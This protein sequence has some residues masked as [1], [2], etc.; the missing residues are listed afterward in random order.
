MAG[1]A[2]AEFLFG[3]LFDAGR[4]AAFAVERRGRSVLCANPRFEDLIGRR[5]AELVGQPMSAL[6]IGELDYR[7]DDIVDRA[8]LY[9]DVAFGQLDGYPLFVDLT[10]AHV[11]H[12]ELGPLAACLARDTTE[13]RTLQRE[14]MA[15]HSAL[16]L[17]HSELADRNREISLLAGQVARVGWRAAI[18]ELAAGVAHHLNNPVAALTSTLRT[19]G[20][21]LEAEPELG[22]RVELDRLLQRARTAAG[23]IEDHV[24]AVV[25]LHRTGALDSAPRNLDLAREIDTALTL[26]TG[27]LGD[28]SVLRGY[29]APLTAHVPQEPL[30][31]VLGNVISNAVTAMVGG[32][33]LDIGVDRRGEH[34]VIGVGDS[35]AGVAADLAASLTDPIIA[36][37]GNGAGLGLATARRLAR[38]WGGD[39]T[40]R[41]RDRGALFEI[42][43]PG[44]L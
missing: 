38:L 14:L 24:A 41:P 8:G 28:I 32:G 20:A 10:I 23:R 16:H 6:L 33:V 2:V 13:R 21:R 34:W 7:G 40:L 36:A 27:R 25:G 44:E 1:D 12:R 22:G 5:A 19:L 17:A 43:V 3:V 35:G 30:H 29:D 39:L 15:K 4:D 37:R 31:H 11:E 42:T 9:E 26:F 18:G